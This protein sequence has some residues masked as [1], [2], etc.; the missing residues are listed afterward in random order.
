LF[1]YSRD[2]PGEH[3]A[4]RLAGWAGIPQADAFAAFGLLYQD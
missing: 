2:R 1:H 3:A 4:R